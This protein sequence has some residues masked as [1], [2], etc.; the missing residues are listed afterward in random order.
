MIKTYS[1]EQTL[2]WFSKGMTSKLVKYCQHIFY[3]DTGIEQPQTV[4]CIS[5]IF[6][7]LQSLLE[8]TSTAVKAHITQIIMFVMNGVRYARTLV[9]TT[10]SRRIN[11]IVERTD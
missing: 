2:F 7:A 1:I 6:H 3:E 5:Q 8:T 10:K 4:K 11:F 9:T